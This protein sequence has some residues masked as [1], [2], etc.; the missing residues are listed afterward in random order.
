LNK[1]VAIMSKKMDGV[2]GFLVLGLVVTATPVEAVTLLPFNAEILYITV[3]PASVAD[4]STTVSNVTAV[5][6][7]PALPG[8]PTP[9]II[10]KP[11]QCPS[12]LPWNPG[13]VDPRCAAF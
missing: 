5:V 12:L 2:L 13:G 4:L 6:A 7:T 10:S 11:I 9:D 3:K 1:E 8:L